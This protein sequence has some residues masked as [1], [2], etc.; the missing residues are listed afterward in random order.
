LEY[1]EQEVE[2]DDD[3]TREVESAFAATEP[4]TTT[5]PAAKALATL[6]SSTSTSSLSGESAGNDHGTSAKHQVVTSRVDVM[7]ATEGDALKP[8]DQKPAE[9]KPAASTS[10]ESSSY[11]V[12]TSDP[13][14]VAAT[15]GVSG[16]KLIGGNI[17][18]SLW[19]ESSD[20]E[21]K[22]LVEAGSSFSF[23]LMERRLMATGV[24]QILQD[25]EDLALKAFVASC[26]ASLQLQID[27]S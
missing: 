26:C 2:S 11:H 18:G 22:F 8:A 6:S 7:T 13:V 20:R 15:L 23:P 1:S 12:T 4:K 10:T 16:A 25:V 3:V 24:G 14:K 5:I 17:V 27:S 19:F 9:T 21:R